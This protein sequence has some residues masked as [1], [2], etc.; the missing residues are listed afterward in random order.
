MAR[1]LLIGS[2]PVVTQYVVER[3]RRDGWEARGVVGAEAGMDALRGASE[4]DAV[5]LG[6]PAVLRHA[7]AVTLCLK[8]THPYAQLVLAQSPE[9]LSDDILHAMGGDYN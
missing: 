1:V 9:D 7:K 6:G 5:V 2:H 4:V 3:L 8:D